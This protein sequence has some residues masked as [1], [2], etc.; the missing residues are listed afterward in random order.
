MITCRNIF[1]VWSKTTL[2]S[3]WPRD[4]IRLD[5]PGTPQFL[6]LSSF[7]PRGVLLAQPES[8]ADLQGVLSVIVSLNTCGLWH[9]TLAVPDSCNDLLRGC[10]FAFSYNFLATEPTYS[11]RKEVQR[12]T[13]SF[14]GRVP[15]Q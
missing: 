6:T 5:I 10:N 14:G 1:N 12:E 13:V 7:T 3:V 9:L 15:L 4:V 2:L 8:C 11:E